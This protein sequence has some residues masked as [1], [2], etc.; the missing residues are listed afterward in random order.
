MMAADVERRR[1]PLA[2]LARR[3]GRCSGIRRCIYRYKT[4]YHKLGIASRITVTTQTSQPFFF[5]DLYWHKM[6]TCKPLSNYRAPGTQASKHSQ[7]TIICHALRLLACSNMDGCYG[8][9][10]SHKA[11]SNLS[12]GQFVLIFS[13]SNG[14]ISLFLFACR[15][16]T[17][18][19]LESP[20]SKKIQ[21]WSRVDAKEFEHGA[22]PNSKESVSNR[23]METLE[24]SN[25]INESIHDMQIGAHYRGNLR[26]T[27]CC[28]KTASEITGGW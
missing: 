26:S 4:P 8:K 25:I 3:R 9:S 17:T 13:T 20:K 18:K 12:P 5:W 22:D 27:G 21:D 1:R 16:P 15:R 19:P 28:V 7:R 24:S 11:T 2:R 6:A 14:N 10:L 23:S